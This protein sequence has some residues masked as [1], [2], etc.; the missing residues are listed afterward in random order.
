MAVGQKTC[1]C[2]GGSIFARELPLPK[3]RSDEMA[4]SSAWEKKQKAA[5][6][7]EAMADAHYPALLAHRADDALCPLNRGHGSG[8]AD[9]F[10]L[11]DD[12]PL[13]SSASMQDVRCE[14]I[15]KKPWSCLLS[16][17]FI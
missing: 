3:H 8:Q 12:W 1:H 17:R 4:Q 14:A 9:L 15:F 10:H 11:L 2:R 6:A 13:C 16:K 5:E 7:V